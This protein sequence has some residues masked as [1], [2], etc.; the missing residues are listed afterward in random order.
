L[1]AGSARDEG[2][3]HFS[4]RKP[5][6][7]GG[8]VGVADAGAILD[9]TSDSGLSGAIEAI[10]EGE[11]PLGVTSL[12]DPVVHRATLYR[13]TAG[14]VVGMVDVTDQQLRPAAAPGGK[15]ACGLV[16]ASRRHLEFSWKAPNCPDR[17]LLLLTQIRLGPRRPQEVP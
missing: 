13:K 9:R 7:N 1:G 11:P 17:R 12:L 8:L 15:L 16:Q 6:S 4:A 3:A 5:D 14:A 2:R 10:L